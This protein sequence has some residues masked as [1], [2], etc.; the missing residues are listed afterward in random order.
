MRTATRKTLVLAG[1][2]AW[3]LALAPSRLHAASPKADK[4]DINSA[5]QSELES[6]PGV[7]A[8]TAKKIIAGRPWSSVSALSKAGVS[9]DTIEKLRPLVKA[10]RGPAA[11]AA[12]AKS[13]PPKAEKPA[14]AAK[15]AKEA[16]KEEKKEE[17]AVRAEPASAAKVD[18]NTASQKELEALPG[19]GA[20]TAKEIVAGRPYSSVRDLSRAGVSEKTIE[21]I[22]PLVTASGRSAEARAPREAAPAPARKPAEAA[23]A[24]SAP[25]EPR[26]SGTIQPP[27]A[28]GRVWVNTDTGVYHREGSQWYGKTKA[29]KYMTE[30]EARKAGYREESAGGAGQV[31][32]NTETKVFHRQGDRWYGNT[33]HG[34]YMSEAE[35]VKEGYRESREHAGK[36]DQ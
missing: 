27:P 20:V 7:G 24:R 9:A 28:S 30:A 36:K 23:P 12:P 6:L 1:I 33:K 13:E 5:S 3:G 17:R 34:K 11:E 19:V 15:E 16:K 2:L 18:L 14:R 26:Y 31:W 29:G 35:A 8:A 10:G 25:S 4:I 21:K 32:V 22:A